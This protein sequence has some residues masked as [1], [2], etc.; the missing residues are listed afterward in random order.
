LQG[1]ENARNEKA[2]KRKTQKF[3]EGKLQGM[4][5]GKKWKVQGTENARK[6][7]WHYS[8]LQLGAVS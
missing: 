5:N 6:Y 7:G 3:K 2:R 4:E 1:V 8:H